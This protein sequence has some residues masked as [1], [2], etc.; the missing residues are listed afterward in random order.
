MKQIL[1][2]FSQVVKAT[3]FMERNL[4]IANVEC[5]KKKIAHAQNVGGIFEDTKIYWGK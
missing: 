1:C 4:M 3:S 5:K 2:Y